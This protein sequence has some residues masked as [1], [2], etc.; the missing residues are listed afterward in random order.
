MKNQKIALLCL[1]ILIG[2]TSI[3]LLSIGAYTD[4]KALCLNGIYM[5]TGLPGIYALYNHADQKNIHGLQLIA[6][7]VVGMFIV[8][9]II[10]AGIG[11]MQRNPVLPHTN[12]I[13]EVSILGLGTNII[14]WYLLTKYTT[15]E[16]IKEHE[17]DLKY[18][19]L[20]SLVAILSST[21]VVYFNSTF[22][23]IFLGV[24]SGMYFLK[25]IWEKLNQ[26]YLVYMEEVEELQS[27]AKQIRNDITYLKRTKQDLINKN[28]ALLYKMVALRKE[29]QT[30]NRL[31]EMKTAA[32]HQKPDSH[33]IDEI[34]GILNRTKKVAKVLWMKI[35]T[36]PN[37]QMICKAR[38][39]MH[40]NIDPKHQNALRESLRNQIKE[41]GLMYH[42]IQ[43]Q[44]A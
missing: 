21:L 1:M 39:K 2:A 35:A 9:D 33:L 19:I 10:L 17:T 29:K 3:T 23:D 27:N 36:E 32:I 42:N 20:I 15:R 41:L 14:S 31:L 18:S 11:K 43:I 37:G 16:W 8:N 26:N 13:I 4:N 22:P 30:L 44:V 40:E 24:G 5:L 28:D 34:L 25:S 38:I 6:T 7:A 12:W